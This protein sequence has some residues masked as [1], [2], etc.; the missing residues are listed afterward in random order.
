MWVTKH[1]I[2]ITMNLTKLMMDTRQSFPMSSLLELVGYN[3]I[4]VTA[5]PIIKKCQPVAAYAAVRTYNKHCPRK[6]KPNS[7]PMAKQLLAGF[8][9]GVL[10]KFY[11]FPKNRNIELYEYPTLPKLYYGIK[12]IEN[13]VQRLKDLV[14]N[15]NDMY[16]SKV[17]KLDFFI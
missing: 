2:R 5:L 12:V 4:Y 8:A 15:N 10:D 9:G 11:S 1:R 13:G 16:I 7:H 6:G 3:I 14:D 17:M